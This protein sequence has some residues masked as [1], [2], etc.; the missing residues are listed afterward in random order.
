MVN[1]GRTARLAEELRV[2]AAVDDKR[3]PEYKE[4]D[5]TVTAWST[6][7]VLFNTYS[8]PSR[9]KGE[10]VRVR[11]YERYIEVLYGNEIQLVTERL[12]GRNG[13]RINYR[14]LIWSLVR[15]PGGFARYRYR[16]ELFPTL[17]LSVST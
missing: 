4:F 7:R 17:T 12:L 14:H 5:V 11:V 6:I 8:V 15:K 3:L 1:R 10:S 9:L 16:D 13:H 2:M